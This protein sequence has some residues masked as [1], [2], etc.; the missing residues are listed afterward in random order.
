MTLPRGLKHFSDYFKEFQ[1]DYVIIGGSAASVYLKDE[2][3]A[4][5]S[6]KDID[7]VLIT[8]NS[9]ALNKQISEYVALGKYQSNEKSKNK[10]IYYR[11]SKPKDDQ[12]PKIIEIF[13]HNDNQIEL[14]EGQ[15]ILP[16]QSDENAQLSAILLDDEYF[17]L[18]KDNAIKSEEGYSIIGPE[19]NVCMKARAFREL[20]D[21]N[22]DEDKI[23]KHKK[24]VIR[25]AQA[26]D[27]TR[28]FSI[29]GAPKKDV[30]KVIAAISEMD[31]REV[32]Q[33]IGAVMSKERVL[34]ILEGCFLAKSS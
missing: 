33:V 9:K 28:P 21:R 22:D 31:E 6:T 26:I 24:D 29:Q 23:N 5:R 7:I 10:P 20:L 25:L 13:A 3:L 34:E 14:K 18:I 27:E 12:F 8:N 16:I 11:F 2:G 4:F 17:R 15:Y 19:V 30:Q 1:D 32:K